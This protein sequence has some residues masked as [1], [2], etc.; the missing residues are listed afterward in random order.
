MRPT[1]S[2]SLMS[3]SRFMIC[4]S[5][6]QLWLHPGCQNL[7]GM[8]TGFQH[9]PPTGNWS[10]RGLLHRGCLASPQ[11][12]Q[13]N[14]LPC[15]VPAMGHCRADH[16][17]PCAPVTLE[18]TASD[19]LHKGFQAGSEKAPSNSAAFSWLQVWTHPG[20]SRQRWG[21]TCQG[22]RAAP[23]LTGQ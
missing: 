8:E 10:C 2:I 1:K 7:G 11:H 9:S 21:L 16:P 22:W 12:S 13:A 23:V 14:G 4:T 6:Q 19:A 5:S 15:P 3:R 17:C 20:S 18:P